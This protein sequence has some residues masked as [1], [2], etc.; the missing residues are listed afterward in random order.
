MDIIITGKVLYLDKPNSNGTIYDRESTLAAI[1]AFNNKPI[2]LSEFLPCKRTIEINLDNVGGVIESL[3]V[4][5]EVVY[6]DVRV[7]PSSNGQ[8]I[9]N[10]PVDAKMMLS[11]RG[12]TVFNPNNIV[13][14]LEIISIDVLPFDG[15]FDD[16]ICTIKNI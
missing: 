10:L 7:I 1:E 16:S 6:A 14:N 4:Q 12:K 11:L 5:D 3:Y 8:K 9:K 13:T 15:Q 2:K